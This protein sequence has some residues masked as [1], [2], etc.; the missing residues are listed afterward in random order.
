[1]LTNDKPCGW[2]PLA[3][4]GAFESPVDS[5]SSNVAHLSGSIA[6]AP[7]RQDVAVY[8]MLTGVDIY[9]LRTRLT[10]VS[11]SH[12][13]GADVAF[14]VKFIH[15]GNFIVAG[16]AVGRVKLWRSKDGR[17]FDTLDH[18]GKLF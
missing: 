6:L 9:D 3:L 14:P 2:C 17:P 12:N 7:N 10:K 16:N 1:M 15:A 18:D 11:M 13:M 8:N 4:L 5:Q